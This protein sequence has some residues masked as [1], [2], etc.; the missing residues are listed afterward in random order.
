VH[1]SFRVLDVVVMGGT[2]Y[3]GLFAAPGRVDRAE[4]SS[5]DCCCAQTGTNQSSSSKTIMPYIG[6]CSEG[7][8]G[9]SGDRR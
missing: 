9:D 5:G 4:S 6:R 3:L 8:E 2:A 7:D 1:S